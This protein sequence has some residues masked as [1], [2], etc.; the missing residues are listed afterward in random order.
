MRH[1]VVCYSD[2]MPY[3]SMGGNAQNRIHDQFAAEVASSI[4]W[5]PDETDQHRASTTPGPNA[6]QLNAQ[7][8]T[9]S[10]QTALEPNARSPPSATT[11]NSVP[12]YGGVPHSPNSPS[13]YA[14][15]AYS[16]YVPPASSPVQRNELQYLTNTKEKAQYDEAHGTVS[17]RTTRG[18]WNAG[19]CS[20]SECTLGANHSGP[21]SH[22]AAPT[23]N[24]L[25]SQATRGARMR[26]QN[27]QPPAIAE[28][29]EEEG[30]PTVGGE[31]LAIDALL[32]SAN[33]IERAP[34]LDSNG[35]HT[36]RSCIDAYAAKVDMDDLCLPTGSP[37]AKDSEFDM[38]LP[39]P[40]D[41][42]EAIQ[43]KNWNAPN[44]YKYAVERECKAWIKQGV[45]KGT[46]WDQIK[47]DL[48][49]LNMRC[50]FTVKTDKKNRFQRAKLRI[51]ILGH[52]H[53]AKPGE[54]Y[55]E[56]FS[57]TARWTSIRAVCAQAC[58][59]GFTIAR[60]VDTGAAFLFEDLEAGAQ[61]LV[62]VPK[63]LG[64]ILGCGEL[65]FCVK[66]AYGLPSAP[67]C[68]FKFVSR[69]CTDSQGCGLTQS[70]QDEAVFYCLEGN[71]YIYVCTWVDDFLVISNCQRLYDR[72]IDHYRRAVD[73]AIEEGDL[74]Y[75]LGVNFEVNTELNTIKLYSEKAISKLVQKFGT[76]NRPSPVPAY[77]DSHELSTVELPVVGSPEHLALRSRA[78][79]YKSLVPTM[80]FIVTTT[81]PDAAHITGLLCQCL[82][83][84]SAA[85]CDAAEVE[86]A[87]LA[88]TPTLG[89][90]YGGDR[91]PSH[92][93]SVAQSFFFLER[94][95][96]RR[97]AKPKSLD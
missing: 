34:V 58:I 72:F 69:V 57:Q 77:E 43:S 1:D 23:V 6:Q 31:E 49:A 51:I 84:P 62:K 75:M 29:P 2:V 16:P 37:V 79:R 44:G 39:L 87:Y 85:H 27:A 81:R 94:R 12:Q 96:D 63:E 95:F 48:R 68:F 46:S 13:G 61:V 25:P 82:D 33:L 19:H 30:S 92:R 74:E 7:Q 56:N 52:Q 88:S 71:D 47:Q 89:V 97:F 76:P 50:L 70:R 91:H 45:L 80:L 93:V 86:L 8:P 26:S 18:E 9:V 78:E 66:A 55:F 5:D 38:T 73:D 67:A 11:G 59:N 17:T 3:R 32:A 42:K 64:D 65:A 36:Y 14:S 4:T 20:N 40:N 54:H 24:G 15:D 21:C 28:E 53:A 10:P 22:M 60:Q 41:I 35:T 83:N 90:C